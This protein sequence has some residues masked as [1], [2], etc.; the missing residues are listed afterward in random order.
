MIE[1][2]LIVGCGDIG[3]RVARLCADSGASVTGVVRREEHAAELRAKGIHAITVNLDDRST[4]ADIPTTGALVY[5][6]APPQ[7]GGS[8]D[9]RVRNFLAS[10]PRG[11]EPRKIIYISTSGVYGDCGGNVVTE[12][13]PVNPQTTRA[14][15]RYDAECSF[16]KW[17]EENGVAVVI[18]RV[19]GIYG[20]GRLPFMQLS[21]GLA[22]L[23]EEEAPYTN[24]IHAE[25][26][27]AVC[28]AAGVKGHSGD[29]FNV[30]DGQTSTMTHY[31][32]MAADAL[33]LPRPRQIT[34]EE[35]R[36]VMPP[37]M[38]SYFS[39]SRRM[40]N[41]RMLEKLGVK[42]KYPTLEEGLRASVPEKE[43]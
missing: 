29:I 12:D 9:V 38:L 43:E 17:G 20:P 14:K 42:L 24:R 4:L 41:R 10:I 36:Q 33:G 2:V 26:L 40:D 31:F 21:S 23:R 13:T 1:K 25:D 35:A 15:R 32:N 34:M 5:Y 6:F 7:G 37:L 11:A 18:L 39:E 30:T 28:F 3:E 22:V 16:R 27:A 19:T 8:V